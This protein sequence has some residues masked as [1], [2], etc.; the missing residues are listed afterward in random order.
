MVIFLYAI[1]G[2]WSLPPPAPPAQDDALAIDRL[3]ELQ[4]AVSARQ[5]AETHAV[6]GTALPATPASGAR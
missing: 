6:H 2:R 5:A 4:Q 1:W 3:E